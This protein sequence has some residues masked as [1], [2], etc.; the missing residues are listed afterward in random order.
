MTSMLQNIDKLGEL[1]MYD[2]EESPNE[3]KGSFTDYAEYGIIKGISLSEQTFVSLD[4]IFNSVK[5]H[6]KDE[7]RP[8][9]KK[10][11]TSC[12]WDAVAINKNAFAVTLPNENKVKFLFV[13]NDDL[14]ESHEIMAYARCEGIDYAENKLFLACNKPAKVLILNMRGEV[15][16]EISND[17]SG[18][19]LFSQPAYIS[20]DEKRQ[21]L[22]VSD[23]KT[24]SATVLAM[25]GTIKGVYKNEN[26]KYPLTTSL[27]ELD[28]NKIFVIEFEEGI[29]TFNTETGVCEQDISSQVQYFFGKIS[30]GIVISTCTRIVPFRK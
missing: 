14:T 28:K 23:R 2:G 24:A 17:E 16:K 29:F 21:L 6:V 11:L 4:S 18:N 22:C 26:M 12:P 30:N 5:L 3:L 7:K 25:N 8:V 1:C 20:V 15:I 10:K 19:N 13:S 27:V 9:I